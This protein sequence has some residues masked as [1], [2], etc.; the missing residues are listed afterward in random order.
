VIFSTLVG[1]ATV[2]W[3]KKW[4]FVLADNLVR[5]IISSMAEVGCKAS[6]RSEGGMGAKLRRGIVVVGG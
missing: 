2:E 5:L 1:D 6:W 4:G 3:E